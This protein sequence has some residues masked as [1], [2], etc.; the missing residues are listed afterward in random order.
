MRITDLQ[1]NMIVKLT[2]PLHVGGLILLPLRHASRDWQNVVFQYFYYCIN[3]SHGFLYFSI[4]GSKQVSN[5]LHAVADTWYQ[6]RI[7]HNWTKFIVLYCLVSFSWVKCETGE[8]FE[9]C[10]FFRFIFGRFQHDLVVNIK[11]DQNLQRICF[12]QV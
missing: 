8:I 1:P 9:N 10:I 3:P 2:P 11:L 12:C 6:L 5:S 7:I 4:V